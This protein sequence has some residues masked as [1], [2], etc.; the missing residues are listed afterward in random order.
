MFILSA[1]HASHRFETL[2]EHRNTISAMIV[3]GCLSFRGRLEQRPCVVSADYDGNIAVWDVQFNAHSHPTKVFLYATC[4]MHA[5]SH[6][7]AKVTVCF[8]AVGSVLVCA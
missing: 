2:R 4:Q 6:V 5:F 1:I 7:H 3:A 8:G